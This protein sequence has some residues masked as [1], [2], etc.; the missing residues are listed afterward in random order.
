MRAAGPVVDHL[1]EQQALLRRGAER[2]LGAR[3]CLTAL[4]S[5]SQAT[6]YAVASTSG[7]SRP[8]EASHGDRSG[9]RAARAASAP[10]GPPREDVGC[11]PW[12]ARGA[13]RPRPATRGR[14][15]RAPGHLGSRRSRASLGRRGARARAPRAVV[16]HLVEVTLDAPS[17]LAGRATIAHGTP[18]PPRAGHALGVQP[19]VV[20]R[21]VGGRA[22]CLD[23]SDPR[24]G[25]VVNEHRE[26][27]AVALERRDCPAEIRVR[28]GRR[29]RPWGSTKASVPGARTRSPAM[30]P[31]ASG[32]VRR[33]AV[34]RVR[35]RVLRA[36]R[37]R[38]ARGASGAGRRARDRHRSD[39]RSPPEDVTGTAITD[40]ATGKRR[41]RTR[42]SP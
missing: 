37:R 41:R 42:R 8:F 36:G 40:R 13:P 27:L 22:R 9:V 12:R 14:A 16:V 31:R 11:M 21:H 5:A 34:G 18:R 24:G 28:E 33:D 35:S 29:V 19:R 20:E 26:G 3:P 4:V 25:R 39:A 2:R 7:G 32:R 23:S 38:R 30:D 10:V 15:A 17:L 6:K 1:D